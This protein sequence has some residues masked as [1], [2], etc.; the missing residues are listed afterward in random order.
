MIKS[1]QVG[2]H[3]CNEWFF[4][5]SVHWLLKSYHYRIIWRWNSI[6]YIQVNQ[7]VSS[8][9]TTLII[10]NFPRCRHCICKFSIMAGLQLI[11]VVC[12]P[13]SGLYYVCIIH[14]KNSN[15]KSTFKRAEEWPYNPHHWRKS[16]W[17][18]EGCI[19]PPPHFFWVGGWPVQ[20]SPPPPHF[21]KIR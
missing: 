13:R 2:L 19:S 11:Y 16:G 6:A 15:V 7:K 21:L 17:G 4:T 12:V 10:A 1:W 20:I 14:S 18:G 3:D 9:W 8:W 5:F